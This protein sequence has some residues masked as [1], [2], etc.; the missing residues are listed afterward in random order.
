[1]DW[2]GRRQSDNIEDERGSSPMDGGSGGGPF[3]G[4]GMGFPGGGMRRGARHP[5][6]PFAEMESLVLR[7]RDAQRR[8]QHEG[9]QPQSFHGD[10]VSCR[11]G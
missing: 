10:S 2:K 3:G 8:R 9:R 6:L 11:S 1:M 5:G 4:G 7:M